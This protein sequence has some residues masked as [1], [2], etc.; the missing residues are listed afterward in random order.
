MS[1]PGADQKLRLLALRWGTSGCHLCTSVPCDHSFLPVLRAVLCSGKNRS[2]SESQLCGSLPRALQRQHAWHTGHRCLRANRVSHGC[3][4]VGGVLVQK[5]P[6]ED[7]YSV[8]FS[9]VTSTVIPCLLP[10]AADGALKACSTHTAVPIG[11]G[12]GEFSCPMHPRNWDLPG[13]R[14]HCTSK[15]STNSPGDSEQEICS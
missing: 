6:V 13:A 11:A 3:S 4:S 10:P 9:R 5:T 15:A 7:K 12:K 1:L 14:T 2:A 8:S